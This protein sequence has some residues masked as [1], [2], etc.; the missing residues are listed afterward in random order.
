MKQRTINA[1]F[2]G[3]SIDAYN[4][5]GA[6]ACFEQT[7][8][9]RFTVY[10]PNAQ[11]IQVIGQFN[12][13]NGDGY[14]L[15]KVDD[16]GVWSLFVA[17]VEVGMAYKYRVTQ[18]HGEVV[19]KM[20]PFA[21]YSELRP[22]TAS[23]VADVEFA[24]SD[25]AW[26]DSRT[27]NFK[28]PMNIY[29]IYL[30]AW[31]FDKNGGVNYRKI[32]K[33]L[34]R[35][36]KKMHYTHV[37]FMP[38]SEYP[39]DGSWGYQTSGY[40]AANS[41]YGTVK[42][43]KY[44]I[45]ELHKHNIGVIFDFVPVHFVMDNYALRKFDG[46]N[47]Y[48]YQDDS[49][50][51]SEW[52]TANFDLHKEEV[53]SFLMS[54]AAYWIKEIHGDGLRMDAISNVIFWQGNKDRG[55]N[56]GALTFVR[57]MNF[58]LHKNFKDV[59]LIA[60]DS[61]DFPNVTKP[62]EQ[63]GLGFDYKWDLGWMNDTLNYLKADPIYRQYE[64]NKITFSMAYFYSENFI[65][66]FSHDEVVHGKAT[67]VQKM[68]GLYEDKFAQARML[69]TYMFTHPGK[70]LNFMGNEIAHMREFDEHQENDWFLL[71]Y[72]MHDSFQ[73][74]IKDLQKIYKKEAALWE[75]DYNFETFEWIDADNANENLYSY[76]RKG[77]S[78]TI[79]VILNMSTNTYKQHQFGVYEQGVY[80]EILNSQKDIYSGMN[81]INPKPLRAKKGFVD[82]KPYYITMDVAPFSGIIL[83]HKNK[84]QKKAKDFIE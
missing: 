70:K 44:L 61:S 34:I 21:F 53:R 83:R 30:G 16:R 2:E 35:Y 65:L 59:M 82:Y 75:D 52:G 50:A 46:T 73:T 78:E 25:E 45:N 67:I 3:Q 68:W 39:F 64:H 47:V 48:E 15:H 9:V 54:A 66:P 49:I 37:E 60:E 4:T 22:E 1:F 43:L 29:E 11:N 23:V 84:P 31:K 12:D 58:L 6:H 42:D 38:L 40:F 74:F 14:D 77:S 80:T 17:D 69:Y 41:R 32:A 7:H 56:E 26:L 57:R 24:W 13:W 81:L 72:P 51:I 71:D 10:A 33:E 27:R 19:D 62:I 55:V 8:G 20:D 76:M 18:A 28:Q 63:N 36:V 5:F 79:V